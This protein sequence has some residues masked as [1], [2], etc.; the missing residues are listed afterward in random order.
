MFP[1]LFP[2]YQTAME[3]PLD[4][5]EVCKHHACVH[6]HDCASPSITQNNS[7]RMGYTVLRQTA[8]DSNLLGEWRISTLHVYTSNL[9]ILCGAMR[10]KK[11]GLH[12]IEPVL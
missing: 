3:Q 12:S 10:C 7:T 9:I 2:F 8:I 6:M 5:R 4:W 11:R 1:I